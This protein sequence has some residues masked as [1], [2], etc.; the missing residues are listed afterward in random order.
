M[1]SK[2]PL[3]LIPFVLLLI[4]LVLGIAA[5]AV[6]APATAVKGTCEL[7]DYYFNWGGY[8]VD[9]VSGDWVMA[10]NWVLYTM[11]GDLEGTY[12]EE[13]TYYGNVKSPVHWSEGLATFTGTLNEEPIPS[14]SA[15]VYGVTW[16]DPD[17]DFAGK[18]HTKDTLISGM[19]GQITIH[20]RFDYGDGR[21]YNVYT[22]ELK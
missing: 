21:D 15:R 20:N 16:M 22:G 19:K 17:Y 18:T 4:V 11:D 7:V 13:V 5:L 2:K 3:L 12:L 8:D 1:R 9:P 14:W 6:A 10:G